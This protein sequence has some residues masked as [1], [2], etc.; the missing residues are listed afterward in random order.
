[1]A[2][3]YTSA[4]LNSKY[5][6]KYGRVDVSAKLPAESGTWPAIWTLGA[7]INETGN[8]FG[9]TYGNVGWPD[10]RNRHYGTKWMGQKYYL[11]ILA[12]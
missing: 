1:M 7:N 10:C 9:N 2:K 5:A 3:N 12:L 6:F 11:R 4:R 8:Y